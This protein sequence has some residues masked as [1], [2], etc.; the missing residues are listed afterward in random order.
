MFSPGI[1]I[2]PAGDSPARSAQALAALRAAL[3]HGFIS[4]ERFTWYAAPR[5][6]RPFRAALAALDDATGAVVGA[7]TVEVVTA[8]SL[9][10]SFMDSYGRALGQAAIATLE[11]GRTGLIKSIAVA[12]AYRGRGVARALI[13]RGLGDLAAHG[14]ERYYALAWESERD[15]CLLRG[16]LTAAGFRTALRLERFWRQDSVAHGYV[17]PACGHPCVCAARVM[18]R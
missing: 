18:V 14:A 16:Q 5:E 6:D 17:C 7:L 13:Q 12:P 8:E 2:A 1:S 9:R 10:D 3:G 11:P 4:D 15:G